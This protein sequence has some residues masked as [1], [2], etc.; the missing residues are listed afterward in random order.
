MKKI[1]EK[2]CKRRKR[3]RR[4]KSVFEISI[5]FVKFVK[6]EGMEKEKYICGKKIKD[7]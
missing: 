6:L 7:L 5:L 2:K 4:K 1:H 3:R